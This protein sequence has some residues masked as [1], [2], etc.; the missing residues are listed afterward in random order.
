MAEP[1]FAV[2]I[3]AI[4]PLNTPIRWQHIVAIVLVAAA[5]V[6]SNVRFGKKVDQ[7]D[8]EGENI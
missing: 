6:F 2:I 7:I 3:G 1:I 8:K 5:I 4:L